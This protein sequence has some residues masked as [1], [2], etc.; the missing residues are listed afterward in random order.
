MQD[1]SYNKASQGTHGNAPRVAIL[2][3][4]YNGEAF[5]AAQ[6][7]S[8]ISQSYKNWV[9]YASDDGSQDGTLKILTNAQR[10]LGEHKLVILRGPGRGFVNNFMSLLQSKMIEAEYFAFCDQDDIWHPNRL[11][12]G[13]S[14]LQK[15]ADGQPALFCSRSRLVDA[16]GDVVGYS[17]NFTTPPSFANA[18]VQNIAG[19]NT[20]LLNSRARQLLSDLAYQYPLIA[21][22]WWCYLLITGCGGQVHFSSDPLIDYRQH[23]KNLIGANA[24]LNNMLTR[25]KKMLNGDFSRWNESNIA[26]LHDARPL[27]KGESSKA[28]DWFDKART[29]SVVHRAYCL[30]RSGAHRQGFIGN[31]ALALA[32]LFNKL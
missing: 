25:L 24:S 19:G 21:H 5:L 1:F 16:A 13:V 3:A 26:T 29:G 15:N 4:T 9:I 31:V 28:L 12:R 7:S 27:L 17:A 20:M 22:D 6:I 23:E 10:E 2:L 14:C 18:L 8:L 30:I 11:E 32:V